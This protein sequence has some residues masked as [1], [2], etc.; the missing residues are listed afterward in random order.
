MENRA[1]A[2]ATGVFILLLGAALAVV[3]AWFQGDQSERSSYTIVSRGG[4]PGLNVKAPVKLRGVLIGKVEKID[5]DPADSRQILIT[6]Q[7]AK[8]APLTS[9]TQAR[10]GY[11]GITGLSYVDLSEPEGQDLAPRLTEAS[12]PLQLTPSLFDRLSNSGP[13][14]MERI[15]EVTLRLNGLLGDENQQNFGRALAGIADASAGAARLSQTLQ[16]TAHALPALTQQTQA[17]LKDAGS[18]MKSFEALSAQS[19]LLV[20]DL[21]ERSQ[22]LQRLGLAANQVQTTMQRLE[23]ALVGPNRVRTQPLFD[24][25]SQG[26]RAVERAANDLGEQPQSLIFGRAAPPPGPGEAGF[27][28]NAKRRP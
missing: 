12:P 27:D 8:A 14:L 2:L 24:D 17:L 3:V 19:T 1:H 10:L 20:Q 21:R 13:Q 26:A 18:A 5:F 28:A 6:I 11:Q 16:P 7:V 4:V 15:G 22:E 25:F 9:A 23:L